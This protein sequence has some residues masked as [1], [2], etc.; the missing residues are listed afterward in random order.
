MEN[1]GG[2]TLAGEQA[3]TSGS[4]AGQSWRKMTLNFAYEVFLSYSEGSFNMP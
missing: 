2:L 3:K 1:N 4:E